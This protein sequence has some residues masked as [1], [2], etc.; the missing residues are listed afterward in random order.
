MNSTKLKGNMDNQNDQ[1]NQVSSLR[2][3][4]NTAFQVSNPDE[5]RGS[6]DPPY[7]IF[8]Y[9]SPPIEIQYNY[10][11]A[12]NEP[13][14]SNLLFPNFR[15]CNSTLSPHTSSHQITKNE[16]S[17]QTQYEQHHQL[18]R[19]QVWR[20]HSSSTMTG[21]D[22]NNVNTNTNS[23]RRHI[24]HANRM[25]ENFN[26]VN[27]MTNSCAI[28]GGADAQR[29]ACH[30]NYMR[31]NSHSASSYRIH[32]PYS[33]YPDMAQNSVALSSFEPVVQKSVIQITNSDNPQSALASAQFQNKQEILVPL[34]QISSSVLQPEEVV[35]ATVVAAQKNNLK[36]EKINNRHI[37]TNV[38]GNTIP[39]NSQQQQPCST[40]NIDRTN[41]EESHQSITNDSERITSVISTSPLQSTIKLN[42]PSPQSTSSLLFVN[43]SSDKN[44]YNPNNV[45]ESP[46]SLNCDSSSKIHRNNEDNYNINACEQN[47]I[48][49]I[50]NNNN[51]IKSTSI[52]NE[53]TAGPSGLNRFQNIN[54]SKYSEFRS[55]SNNMVVSDSD[56]SDSDS[57]IVNIR[58]KTRLDY[59]NSW[60]KP[61]PRAYKT[62]PNFSL[63]PPP[64]KKINNSITILD[65]TSTTSTMSNKK[66]SNIKQNDV[67]TAPDLQL[68][69]LSDSSGED[70][71][72]IF[73]HSSREP[74]TSID[75]T[76]DDDI[77]TSN[78]ALSTNSDNNLNSNVF[79]IS[80][81]ISLNV[82]QH[83][84]S[85]T[86]TCALSTANS[87]QSTRETIIPTNSNYY[88]Q[89]WNFTL[90]SNLPELYQDISNNLVRQDQP[91]IMLNGSS[92][93]YNSSAVLHGSTISQQQ[94]QI[95]AP[96]L[97]QQ[98][99]HHS[100]HLHHQNSAALQTSNSNQ[101][102][103]PHQPQVMTYYE[104]E[105]EPANRDPYYSLLTTIGVNA[106][107]SE[108]DTN[109]NND[110]VMIGGGDDSNSGTVIDSEINYTSGRADIINDISAT[111]SPPTAH[112]AENIAH[113]P[114][115]YYYI[116]NRPHFGHHHHRRYHH[117]VATA[118]AVASSG[119]I[120][121]NNN[122]QQQ[123]QNGNTNTRS[124]VYFTPHVPPPY[125]VHENLWHR[126]QSMQEMH[127]RHMIPMDLS[128]GRNVSNYRSNYSNMCNCVASGGRHHRR[129]PCNMIRNVD[130]VY[131]PMMSFSSTL[132]PSHQ[133]PTNLSTSASPTGHQ[134]VHH[135][136]FHHYP[137]AHNNCPPQHSL[138]LS[139]GLRST[140]NPA[141]NPHPLSLMSGMSHISNRAHQI[142]FGSTIR[143]SRG[144][145]L[146][147]IERNT[148]PHKYK[149]IRRPSESDEDAEK[150]A[151][152]LSLFEMENDV[153]RL[154]CMH[155]FHMDCVD[156]WL[157]T[158]K[159]CPI[160]RVDIETHLTKDATTS[161]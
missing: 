24:I 141:T 56:S 72:I 60:I 127:R 133:P 71:D 94:H 45:Y 158:N 50:S 20:E 18:H 110:I 103:Q 143:P 82:S 48:K 111:P 131:A 95:P 83:N 157:V 55:F 124:A 74:V 140:I 75:L 9:M 136:M 2:E 105:P 135:H 138:H 40:P 46:E 30:H 63:T 134:H 155:L 32:Q 52:S 21:I 78:V 64:V 85:E 77:E 44:N 33:Y 128:S 154:P 73:V 113:P 66:C 22:T 11:P 19:P 147:V 142:L 14:S 53:P 90:N 27:K 139:I 54:R 96:L 36:T 148:L 16:S 12:N 68:D 91:P 115:P 117:A 159:H 39:K 144:A 151:I 89:P 70:D 123:L 49:T 1:E 86:T 15:Q 62:L 5:S 98:Q 106:Q 61:T 31:L 43:E 4:L 114:L 58:K 79:P 145:T 146:A 28:C 149:R 156:Q 119:G 137:S 41:E 125:A 3:I 6:E 93:S 107:P 42:L 120:T 59:T 88:S 130:S 116:S 112:T 38:T 7:D 57:E 160:C 122:E 34:K 100:H 69:W 67:L 108:D 8:G 104:T 26:W 132:D 65:E 35:A 84:P 25:N 76:R 109:R 121:T 152:C 99:S 80:S 81:V 23:V 47:E 150:C 101:H 51:R 161:L 129:H 126:Q 97:Q 29:C 13:M 92:P 10:E 153:R 102:L 118:A 37:P 87:V 17:S